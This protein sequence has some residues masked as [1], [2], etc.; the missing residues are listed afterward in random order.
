[1]WGQTDYY[2]FKRIRNFLH[3]LC[4][5]T[6]KLIFICWK[7]HGFDWDNK[8]KIEGIETCLGLK[9]FLVIKLIHFL[10]SP[11]NDNVLWKFT[12]FFKLIIPHTPPHPRPPFFFPPT[13][14]SVLSS[15][16]AV[17]PVAGAGLG[18]PARTVASGLPWRGQ[19]FV[20]AVI[21]RGRR[22]PSHPACH[23]RRRATCLP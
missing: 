22:L 19:G 15:K 10:K 2:Y 20:T 12:L 1:M 3:F 5:H 6:G 4:V 14:P 7:Q 11:L 23:R 13:V 17:F 9:T 16:T 8:V 21:K 18:F